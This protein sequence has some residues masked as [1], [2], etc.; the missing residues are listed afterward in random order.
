MDFIKQ[1]PLSSGFIAI[2]VVVDHLSK[3]GI[4]IPTANTI[5]LEQLVL[6]FIM[7]IHSKQGVPNHVTSDHGTEFI[8]H[9]TCA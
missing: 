6:L 8:S 9:F 3:Q 1:L 5:D 2:L 7:H 4:F